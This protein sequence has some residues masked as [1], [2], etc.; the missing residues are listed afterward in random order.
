MT[1][2]TLSNPQSGMSEHMEAA[3]AELGRSRATR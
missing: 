1:N 2:R 3:I